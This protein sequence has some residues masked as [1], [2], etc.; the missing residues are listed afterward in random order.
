[1]YLPRNS[2]KARLREAQNA[3]NNRAEIVKALSQGQITRRELFKW[4]IFTTTGMLALKNG[5]SPFAPSKASAAIPT[6]VPSSPLFGAQPFTQPMPRLAL[7]DPVPLTP[8][9]MGN[10]VHA[11]F[12]S[13]MGE[14][15][16]KRLSW[17]TD[18]SALGTGQFGNTWTGTGP[19]E[20]RPPGEFFAHQRWN[21]YFPKQ[22]YVM[23][24]GQC[25]AETYFHEGMPD[26]NQNSVWTLNSGRHP[27]D[28]LL[29]RNGQRTANVEAC[30]DG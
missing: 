16:A 14:D 8:H 29:R 1:M 2:S 22:A 6:G 21:E 24:L 18:F 11:K 28:A 27:V 20:G 13:G 3:R 12:P 9:Q 19:M 15:Y 10:E 17:H 7:Q 4:G 25:D 5:L 30:G 26:Q 23:S